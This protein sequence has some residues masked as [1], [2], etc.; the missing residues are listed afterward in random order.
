MIITDMKKIAALLSWTA[1][2]L[3]CGGVSA[4]EPK[5][6]WVQKGVKSLN[7]ARTNDSYRFMVFDTA[8]E[9]IDRLL[10]ERFEPLK[11][12]V[13]REY[14]VSPELM[15]LDTVNAGAEGRTTC[16]I[17]FETEGRNEEVVAQLVDDWSCFGD[18][19]DSWGFEFSQ[20][21]AVSE[22]NTQPVFDNF[23]VTRRYNGIAAVMSIIPGLGQI[24]KG[25]QAKGYTIMGAEAVFIGGTIFSAVEMAKYRR[26]AKDNP[27]VASSYESN[28]TTFRQ[29]RNT[30]LIAGGALYLYNLI[31]AAVAKGARR[32]T[33]KRP[34][35]TDAELAFAPVITEFGGG[36]GLSVRF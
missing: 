17:S 13:G 19:V 24:Y 32:V 18:E 30:C 29:L 25:Q 3:L 12:Y 28:V 10:S 11:E 36:V 15:V 6:R 14:G 33:V 1:C 27:G 21:Y 7:R 4:A 23:E 16:R 20:L 35:N 22:R 2:L 9:D 26:F 5:P 8:G 31:D 34:N